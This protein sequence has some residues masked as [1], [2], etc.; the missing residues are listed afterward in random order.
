MDFSFELLKIKVEVLWASLTNAHFKN[1]NFL[2]KSWEEV[3]RRIC[4]I[5]AIFCKEKIPSSTAD[6]CLIDLQ[7]SKPKH[8]GH[9]D[10]C[11]ILQ[12][13]KFLF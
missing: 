9:F 6:I 3:Y 5:Y 12:K 2:E 13:K 8:Y 7:E 10:I 11:T 1:Y 4:T